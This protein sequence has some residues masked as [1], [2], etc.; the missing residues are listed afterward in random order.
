MFKLIENECV[1]AL[2][3]V[4]VLVTV[5]FLGFVSGEKIACSKVGMSYN[6]DFGCLKK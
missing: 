6:W 2:L 3:L 5:F 4:V 1:S